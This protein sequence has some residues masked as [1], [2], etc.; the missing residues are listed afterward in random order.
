MIQV[1]IDIETLG[2]LPGS[3]VFAIGAVVLENNRES[4]LH[5]PFYSLINP[6]SAQKHGMTTDMSTLEW[7]FK[8][9]V[10]AREQLMK[11]FAQGATVE[12]AVT[13]LQEWYGG[14]PAPAAVWCKGASFDFPHLKVFFRAA[15]QFTPWHYQ[16]ERCYRTLMA[17]Y[18]GIKAAAP[19]VGHH[20]LH[21]ARAQ[22]EH[23]ARLLDH[24][25]PAQE[26]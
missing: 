14:L 16:Q 13:R 11:A 3:V 10:E 6:Q 23:L 7:W 5:P 20:A 26:P 12:A 19:V 2:T 1:M 21:D 18:P 17:L 8:Q 15:G 25:H 4:A 22:G 9:P 24:C